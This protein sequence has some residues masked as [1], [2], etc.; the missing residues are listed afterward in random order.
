M[1]IP[2]ERQRRREQEL[3]TSGRVH[4]RIKNVKKN[5]KVPV[6]RSCG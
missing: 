6:T 4:Y 5:E 1:V 3:E 2:A